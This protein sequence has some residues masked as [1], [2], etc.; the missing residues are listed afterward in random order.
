VVDNVP[1]MRLR[2]RQYFDPLD[3]FIRQLARTCN[4]SRQIGSQGTF[5]ESPTLRE[6]IGVFRGT[7][8]R[9]LPDTDAIRRGQLVTISYYEV[10]NP[11]VPE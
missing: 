11:S 9:A 2:I 8:N 4:S 5:T 7:A 10:D 3:V 1:R 6:A